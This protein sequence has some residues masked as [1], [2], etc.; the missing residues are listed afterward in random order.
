MA[1]PHHL[2]TPLLGYLV[3]GQ[4]RHVHPHV[5]RL[6][7]TL[8]R[9]EGRVVSVDRVAVGLGLCSRHQLARQLAR[10]GA[11]PFEELAGWTQVLVWV[12]SWE[13]GHVTLAQ[14]ALAVLREP[15]ACYRTVRRVTGAEWKVVRM[16]G[17]AWVLGE[18][19]QRIH[20]Q[21]QP[22]PPLRAMLSPPRYTAK[23]GGELGFDH[24]ASP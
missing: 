7:T 24:T 2:Y 16:R 12:W 23:T 5:L 3:L 14:S 13:I 15:A 4:L 19:V 6:L 20:P 10:A 1:P 11:P 18:L 21:S 22:H 9:A 17:V 8:L